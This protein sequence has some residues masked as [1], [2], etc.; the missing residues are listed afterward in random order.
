[1]QYL[2]LGLYDHDEQIMNLD[3]SSSIQ[4]SI[5]DSNISDI[6]GTLI[7]KVQNGQALFDEITFSSSP[8]MTNISYKLTHQDLTKTY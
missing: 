5:I 6:D 7:V 8:G 2:S 1:M 4:I 3:S